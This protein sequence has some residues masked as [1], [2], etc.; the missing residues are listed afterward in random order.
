MTDETNSMPDAA[1]AA[2]FSE[3]C[4]MVVRINELANVAS[5]VYEAEV[6]RIA[7]KYGVEIATGQMSDV[8]QVKKPRARKW[9]SEM[10]D[11]HPALDDLKALD[12]I[13]SEIRIGPGNMMH[14]RPVP[15]RKKAPMKNRNDS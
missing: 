2:S 12:A 13:A 6:Q 14:F 7:N 15:G 10:W 1:G 3:L 8:W 11:K 9:L 4:A 5:L